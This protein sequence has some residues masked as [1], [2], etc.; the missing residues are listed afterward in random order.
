MPIP[1]S[2]FDADVAD[3]K[4]ACQAEFGNVELVVHHA[5]NAADDRVVAITRR[6]QDED[7]RPGG[8]PT[9]AVYEI[10]EVILADFIHSQPVKGDTC[11]ANGTDYDIFQVDADRRGGADLRLRARG[12]RWDQ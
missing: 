11:T 12:Q 4:R 10:L 2:P 5:N 6:A 9:S 1:I 7:L 8:V 3:L